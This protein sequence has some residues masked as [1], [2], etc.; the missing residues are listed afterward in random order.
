MALAGGKIKMTETYKYK[1]VCK[2]CYEDKTF[3]IPKGELAKDYLVDKKCW[4]CGC[5]LKY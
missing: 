1:A 3:E 4:N 2:N 5:V